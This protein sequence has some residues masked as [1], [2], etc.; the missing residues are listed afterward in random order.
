MV[1][2]GVF[3]TGSACAAAL[4]QAGAARV[5]LFTFARPSRKT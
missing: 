2:F 1:L 3:A 5:I 4:K